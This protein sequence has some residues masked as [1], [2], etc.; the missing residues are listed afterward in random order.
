MKI[1]RGWFAENFDIICTLD[2]KTVF[3]QTKIIGNIYSS[4]DKLQ[5]YYRSDVVHKINCSDCDSIYVGT[6]KQNINKR[7]AC[8]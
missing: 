1:L 3:C 2:T 6:T 8:K 7:A 5:L 4:V